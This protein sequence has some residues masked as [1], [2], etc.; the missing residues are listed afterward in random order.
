[1]IISCFTTRKK[2]KILSTLAVRARRR[3]ELKKSATIELKYR[4]RRLARLR[5]ERYPHPQDKCP[6]GGNYPSDM[7]W[8]SRTYLVWYGIFKGPA[9]SWCQLCGYRDKNPD[10]RLNITGYAIGHLDPMGPHP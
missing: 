4:A 7:I 6:N 10:A 1:M 8:S 5:K 3:Q 9:K 2:G